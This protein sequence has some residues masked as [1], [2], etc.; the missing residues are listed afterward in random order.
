MWKLMIVTFMASNIQAGPIGQIQHPY[1]FA[2]QQA[3]EEFKA[4]DWKVRV[5]KQLIVHDAQCV[6]LAERT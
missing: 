4:A 1:D 6:Q 3:C 2:D 5:N